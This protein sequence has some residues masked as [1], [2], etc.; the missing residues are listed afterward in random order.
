[1]QRTRLAKSVSDAAMGEAL[2]QLEYKASLAGSVIVEADRF[3]PS[4]KTCSVCSI[5]RKHLGLGE[6][7]WTCDACGVVHDRD[8][9]AA[10]NLK[11]LAEAHS[12]TACRHGSAGVDLR[13]DVKL[14]FGQESGSLAV[15]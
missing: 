10:I 3:Y 7:R 1:M 12:V 11:L 15:N 13:I 5:V 2:R 14:P 4:S 9:N 8:V 6:R